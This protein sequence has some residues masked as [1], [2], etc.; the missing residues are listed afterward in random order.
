MAR[1]CQLFSGSQGNATYIGTNSS[2]ILVD[3]GVSAKRINDRLNELDIDPKSIKAIFITHEHTDHIK[4][5]RVFAKKN[6][7][8]VYATSLTLE[9]LE[10]GG[11]LNGDFN[12]FSMENSVELDDFK[13]SSFHTSHDSADSCGYRIELSDDRKI[14]VCTDLGYVSDTVRNGIYGCDLVVLESNHDVN[15]L[16][17]N[18]IY[19]EHLKRRILG[20]G[21]H[22]S[23]V[24]C[25]RELPNLVKNGTTRII[26]AHLSRE[27]N[28]PFMALRASTTELENC[29]AKK[30]VDYI[31][32]AAG[33]EFNPM[34][35]F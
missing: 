14:A 18:I 4:G 24:D 28:T 7:I 21:G 2:G 26:L 25:S 20:V 15:M 33:V 17:A 23:N 22:L 19:P 6:N 11:H 31:I 30:D 13:V 34:I 10:V 5:L 8:D 27:N 16:K 9:E 29:G 1:V 32:N 35:R 12:A 3:V